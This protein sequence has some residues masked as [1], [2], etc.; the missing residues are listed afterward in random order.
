MSLDQCLS[1]EQSYR[2][3]HFHWVIDSLFFGRKAG[4][5]RGF[6]VVVF[7][8]QSVHLIFSGTQRNQAG[9]DFGKDVIYEYI[10]NKMTTDV[11]SQAGQYK[12]PAL[13]QNKKQCKIA[14]STFDQ[15]QVQSHNTMLP[16][17]LETIEIFERLPHEETDETT[18]PLDY[19]SAANLQLQHDRPSP[20]HQP[21]WVQT[22]SKP[23]HSP[24]APNH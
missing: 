22:N 23:L 20:W 8:S 21:D 6:A 24:C 14:R 1:T 11:C 19:S 12:I 4:S 18:S 10:S 15:F 9:F 17:P 7:P 3:C 2:H 13:H 5:P 16:P